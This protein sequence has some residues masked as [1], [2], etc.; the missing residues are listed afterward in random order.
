[1]GQALRGLIGGVSKAAGQVADNRITR[2]TAERVAAQRDEA[3]KD[4]ELRIEEMMKR[5]EGR[6]VEARITEE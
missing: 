2:Y 6:A 3:E 1:M 5:S 4:K